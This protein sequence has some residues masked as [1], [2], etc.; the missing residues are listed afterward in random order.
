MPDVYAMPAMCCL[1]RW[2]SKSFSSNS[3]RVLYNCC[4]NANLDSYL[5]WAPCW[6]SA[7]IASITSTSSAQGQAVMAQKRPP[8]RRVE[9]RASCLMFVASFL[10]S[11]ISSSIAFTSSSNASTSCSAAV[12]RS[13]NIRI[14]RFKSVALSTP[15]CQ[16]PNIPGPPAA[17][18]PEGLVASGAPPVPCVTSSSSLCISSTVKRRSGAPRG[19]DSGCTGL[20][21]VPCSIGKVRVGS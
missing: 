6:S 13:P 11:S 19:D 2:S 21:W 8:P 1:V 18:V 14:L 7:V 9:P 20:T 4:C 16:V 17:D 10:H 12:F 15:P 5:P 3:A